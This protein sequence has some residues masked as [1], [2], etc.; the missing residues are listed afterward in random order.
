M[1]IAIHIAVETVARAIYH[2]GGT[3]WSRII[4]SWRVYCPAQATTSDRLTD[5]LTD[6]FVG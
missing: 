5:L 2:T 3:L 4:S 6:Y 1:A